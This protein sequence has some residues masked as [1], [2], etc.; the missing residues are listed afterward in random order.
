MKKYGAVIDVFLK[1]SDFFNKK[2]PHKKGGALGENSLRI[3]EKRRS[4]KN[5]MWTQ[6]LTHQV[7]K[8]ITT[9]DNSSH[10]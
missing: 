6:A 2:R 3:I 7:L 1:S 5:A 10:V 8:C 4:E 9:W